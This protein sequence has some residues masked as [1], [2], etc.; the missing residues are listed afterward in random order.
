MITINKIERRNRIKK[1]IRA[2]IFGSAK[3]PRLSIF[4]SNKF[5]Y[6]QIIDD[7]SGKTLGSASDSKFIKGNKT[8]RAEEVGSTIGKIAKS[9]KI[10]KIV[11]DRSGYKY[12]GRIKSLAEAVRKTGIKF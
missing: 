3:V 9:K 8:A 1:R 10:S 2:R 4:K 12:T 11:F 5:I 6:A 7:E